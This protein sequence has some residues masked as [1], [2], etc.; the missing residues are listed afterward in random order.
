MAVDI[1]SM[2]IEAQVE[3]ENRNNNSSTNT[4]IML[5]ALNYPMLISSTSQI[6]T[7]NKNYSGVLMSLKLSTTTPSVGAPSAPQGAA[8]PPG[9][10]AVEISLPTPGSITTSTTGGGGGYS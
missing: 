1:T 5:D 4:F 7:Q 9:G 2:G 6:I 3:S 10:Q 8:L